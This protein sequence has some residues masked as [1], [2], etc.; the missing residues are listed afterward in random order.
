MTVDPIVLAARIVL[1]LQTL[2]SREVDPLDPAV[3]TVG[4]IHG[5][6]KHNII[7]PEVILQITV[8]STKEKVRQH[9][10]AGI[11]RIAEAAAKG[12][13]APPPVV[14]VDQT[15]YTPAL[16]N[17]PA[18]TKRTVGVFREVLGAENVKERPTI[19]GGEDFS[20]Y[21]QGEVPIFLFW[22]G[23]VDPKRVEEAAKDPTKALPS[24]HSEFYAP[25][26]EPSIRTGVL[27][28]SRAV[29]ELAKK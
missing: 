16:Y 12:A 20:R 17:D 15:E 7:P 22:L 29:L 25:V 11:K 21:A 6:T 26:P 9:L 27:A 5:G 18:L 24:M 10:L 8:R 28:M 2:V 23:T 13:N 14:K 3:V 4:S 19:M 1:D